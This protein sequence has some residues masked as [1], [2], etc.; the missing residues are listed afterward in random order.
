[1]T[2][3]LLFYAPGTFVTAYRQRKIFAAILPMPD[4]SFAT[5][6]AIIQG[7]NKVRAT[8]VDV[9]RRL[10]DIREG[11]P[12]KGAILPRTRRRPG[13]AWKNGS[14]VHPS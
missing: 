5:A 4:R 7:S 14:C 12:G 3:D 11:K 10:V 1:V 2:A 13:L 8:A 9:A 6:V